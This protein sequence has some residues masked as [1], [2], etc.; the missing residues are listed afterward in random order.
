MSERGFSVLE[1][2]VTLVIL[3]MVT[4]VMMQGLFFTLDVRERVIRN[5][6]EARRAGLED[7]WFRDTVQAAI[8]DSPGS[9][10]AFDG[11]ATAIRFTTLDP[12]DGS[13]R[14]ARI[15]WRIE[16]GRLAYREGSAPALVVARAAEGAAFRYLDAA[17][18][19]HDAWP[20]ASG[21]HLP[22]AVALAWREDG[23]E[24]FRL[25]A[26]GADAVLP[27]PLRVREGGLDGAGP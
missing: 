17:G 26:I 12:L 15:E 24:R 14:L 8:A 19:W 25:A 23:R 18:G 27:I 6:A 2:L 21:A 9:A 3:A 4:T 16:G 13:Q 10:G 22:R 20:P 5:D 11:D 7:A 1:A